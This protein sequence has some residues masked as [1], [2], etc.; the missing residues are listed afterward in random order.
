MS[1]FLALYFEGHS[2]H[3]AEDV[4]AAKYMKSGKAMHFVIEKELENI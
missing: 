4:T 1:V 3:I 2:H